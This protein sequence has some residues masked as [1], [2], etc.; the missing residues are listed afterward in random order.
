MLEGGHIV[1]RG[2]PREL[3]AEESSVL[4]SLLPQGVDSQESL[5]L[6]PTP[7]RDEYPSSLS[8]N[9]VAPS[10][11]EYVKMADQIVLQVME[12]AQLSLKELLNQERIVEGQQV[13]A[14]HV[15]V[16]VA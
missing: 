12:Q 6:P 14:Q 1:E 9:T 13:G 15:D 10:T 11:P 8:P 2:C 16:D 7:V 4:A 5:D 3:L